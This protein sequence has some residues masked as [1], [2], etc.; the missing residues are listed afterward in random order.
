MR[1]EVLFVKTEDSCDVRIGPYKVGTREFPSHIHPSSFLQY[2]Y[3]S[4]DIGCRV[5][6]NMRL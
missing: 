3:G 4:M 5:A 1:T 6:V 2:E